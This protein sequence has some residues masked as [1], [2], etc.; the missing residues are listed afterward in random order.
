VNTIPGRD[1]FYVDSRILPSYPVDEVVDEADRIARRVAEEGGLR[2]KVETTHREDAAEPTPPDSAVA[3]ALEKAVKRVTGLDAR[4]MGIGGG[5]VAALFRK[6][7]LPAA[8]WSTV[9]DTA[10]QPNES[11]SIKDI[12]TDA[13]VLSCIYLDEYE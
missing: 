13:K 11:C 9:S 3:A 7:G 6:A 4:P 2:I 5:T 1:V 10:H 12:I 8:V